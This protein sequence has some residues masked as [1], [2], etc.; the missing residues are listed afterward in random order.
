MAMVEEQFLEGHAKATFEGKSDPYEAEG[1]SEE[2]F[3]FGVEC[4]DFQEQYASLFELAH[5]AQQAEV[6]KKKSRKEINLKDLDSATRELFE[7]EAGADQKEWN[8]W[9]QKDA[10]EVLSLEESKRVLRE[11]PQN[12]ILTRWVRTNK[13]D[14]KP[15]EPFFAKSRLVVQGFK[16]RSLGQ[17]RR[18]VL[19]GLALAE[20]LVLFISAA[21]RFSLVCK[22]IKNA[23]FSGRELGRELY[24]LPPRGG[25]RSQT[26]KNSSSQES[27]IWLC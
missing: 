23:Y 18:D 7:G 27:H 3:L 16:N 2:M 4:N 22:D 5:T 12:T 6:V 10:C 21:F 19:T 9:L 24:L 17:N 11:K 20:S 25:L 14:M 15:D 26:R 8:A 13:N 1:I